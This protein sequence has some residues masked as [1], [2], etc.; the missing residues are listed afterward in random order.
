MVA[1]YWLIVA[2]IGG[3]V[4]ATVS[5]NASDWGNIVT[6]TLAWIAIPFVYVVMV[7]INFSRKFIK[8]IDKSQEKCYNKDNK[9]VNKNGRKAERIFLKLRLTKLRPSGQGKEHR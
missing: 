8:P 6:E 5:W 7:A 4:F 3:L 1:W 2:F 9:G